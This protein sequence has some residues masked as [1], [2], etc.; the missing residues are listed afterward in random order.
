MATLAGRVG[1]TKSVRVTVRVGADLRSSGKV[2]G[3]VEPDS[4]AVTV[5]VGGPVGPDSVAVTVRGQARWARFGGG[6]RG[7]DA[8]S[9]PRRLTATRSAASPLDT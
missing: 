4:V 5:S 9:R 6:N 8:E 1:W 2:G 7:R 3:P